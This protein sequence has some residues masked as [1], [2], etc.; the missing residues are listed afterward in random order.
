MKVKAAPHDL[1]RAIVAEHHRPV[2]GIHIVKERHVGKD[3]AYAVAF[4]DRD[5]AQRRGIVGLRRH[6]GGA[7]SPSGAFM[8]SVRVTGD[9]DV[10]MTWGSWGAGDGSKRAGFG[11][12]VADAA[13]VSAR[14]TD[15][16]GRTIVDEVE[17]GVVLFFYKGSFGLR[18]ARVDLLDAEGV[19]IRSGTMRA[20]H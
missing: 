13:A 6:D 1:I 10:W 16:T 14:I 12:W 9:R 15:A 3:T 2:A 19:V 17:N 11:G 5:G 8:G 7:W 20:Q 18:D 4:E